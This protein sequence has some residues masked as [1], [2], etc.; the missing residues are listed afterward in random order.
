MNQKE[1]ELIKQNQA[2]ESIETGISIKKSNN[3]EIK[4]SKV[5]IKFIKKRE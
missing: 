2:K 3:E 4:P 1:E 5:V